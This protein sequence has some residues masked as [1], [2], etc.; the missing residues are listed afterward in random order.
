MPKV[1]VSTV[2]F[3]EHDQ[4]PIKLLEKNNISYEINPLGRRLTSS[5]LGEMLEDFDCL[6]AGTEQITADV[7]HQTPKLKLI[8]RVGIGLDSVDLIAAKNLGINV[9]YTPDAPAPAVAELSIGLMLSLMRG[10]NLANLQLHKGL[11]ERQSG[12]RLPFVKVGLVGYGRI[13]SR[14]H[15][16]LAQLG[17]QEIL[18][19]ETPE[20]AVEMQKSEVSCVDLSELLSHSDLISLHV[21]LNPTTKNLIQA[22][23]LKLMKPTAS[24]LNTSR[25]GILNEL[26]LAEFLKKNYIRSAAVDVFEQEPYV[27]PLTNCENCLLTAHMGSM[28]VDCRAQMEIEATKEVVSFLSDG[29]QQSAVPKEEY[30]LRLL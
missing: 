21:P 10:I 2:P 28:S 16:L 15:N 9:S 3:A 11:W 25:G 17:V 4:T 13:G 12:F 27:G 5:E 23:E 24:I 7:L 30:A 8:S 6:I 19:T 26:D 1:F 20:K 18:V 14:V 29:A 22:R